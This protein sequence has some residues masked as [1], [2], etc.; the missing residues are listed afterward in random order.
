MNYLCCKGVEGGGQETD[1][2]L[3]AES[4][5]VAYECGPLQKYPILF[6]VNF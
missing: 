4:D 2:K 1:G 3:L 6:E 5:D